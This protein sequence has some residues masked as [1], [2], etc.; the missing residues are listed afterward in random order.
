MTATATRLALPLA[1]AV[2]AAGA[3]WA[4]ADLFGVTALASPP[5]LAEQ[6]VA[7][8]PGFY[9]LHAAATFGRAAL[10]FVV[11]NGVALLTA[12][13]VLVIPGIEHHVLQIAVIAQ[14]LPLV[15]IGPLVMIIFGGEASAVFLSA[16][17][18][19][20]PTLISVIAGAKSASPASIDLVRAYGGGRLSQLRIVRAMTA[21]PSMLSALRIAVP[22]AVLGAVIGEYLGGISTGLGV[23]MSSAQYQMGV[24]RLWNLA[25]VTVAVTLLAYLVA[26]VAERMLTPWAGYAR[27]RA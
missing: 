20:Y 13:L 17:L 26:A 14:C 16:L 22:A 10:G 7:D 2:V 6:F 24:A 4:V 3:W 25:L 11:G 9:A 23:A 19:S 12:F 15:A 18:V 21:L 5:R 1:V 27:V 8:G